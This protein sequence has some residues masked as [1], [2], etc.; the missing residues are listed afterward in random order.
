M[1]RITNLKLTSSLYIAESG[2]TLFHLDFN[3]AFWKWEAFPSINGLLYIAANS[4]GDSTL[5]D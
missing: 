3:T 2:I 5:L 1:Q 4:R